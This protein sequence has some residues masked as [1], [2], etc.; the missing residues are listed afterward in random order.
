M[1]SEILIRQAEKM[2]ESG[3]DTTDY[4]KLLTQPA[5]D[6]MTKKLDEQKRI[7]DELI[8]TM[9]AGISID[10]IPEE[11]RPAITKK[12]ADAKS[13]YVDCAKIIGSGIA[14]DDP[15]YL[16]CIEKMNQ[17]RS[18][19]ETLDA[20]M[21]GLADK[22]KAS[23][24]NRHKKSKYSHLWQQTDHEKF[25]NKVIYGDVTIGED[26][27]LSYMSAD[28]NKKLVSD[29][30]TFLTSGL[31]AAGVDA[32]RKDVMKNAQ[33]GRDFDE[34]GN[35]N[36]VTALVN[37]LGAKGI[38]DLMYSNPIYID[39]YIRLNHGGVTK[40][41]N[42]TEYKKIY[43]KLKD[44]DLTEEFTKH[45]LGTKEN[46]GMLRNTHTAAFR[47]YTPPGA[48]K[49]PG[50]TGWLGSGDALAVQG[51]NRYLDYDVAKDIYDSF[52][53]AK[54]GK[55]SSF[56]MFN[57]KYDYDPA[58]DSWSD[59]ETDFGNSESFRKSLGISESDFKEITDVKIVTKE[60]DKEVVKFQK[61]KPEK[62]IVNQ[63]TFLTSADSAIKKMKKVLPSGWYFESSKSFRG[64]KGD[65]TPFARA[66]DVV[67]IYNENGEE[68][69]EYDV[70]FSAGDV[71]KAKSEYERF[72]L[73]LANFIT[74]GGELD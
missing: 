20:E 12:I 3:I 1:A 33:L 23:L 31:G 4:A 21:T 48:T 27:K 14:S 6:V 63:D 66:G 72:E 62:G 29:Y 11:L 40:E 34:L 46:P 60:G 51:G 56:N 30:G 25:S 74:G 57:V 55:E 17:I 15:K 54:D 22:V 68:M 70:N 69:G 61:T 44:E 28:G 71:A 8:N 24:E 16:E 47:P 13:E 26:F 53:I 67:T 7:T 45:L 2:Y 18:G 41:N 50:E 5:V 10:K 39:E 58:K 19:F 64:K 43:E 37:E 35:S 49:T 59:G 32:L 36:M 38:G 65:R 42:E 9:P 52:V 73:D